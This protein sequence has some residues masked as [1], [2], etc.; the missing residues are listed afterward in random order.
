MHE[1]C[2]AQVY[3]AGHCR[4]GSG[5]HPE[6]GQQKVGSGAV[7][8]RDE[9]GHRGA[10]ED[11]EGEER[12]L[13][14]RSPRPELRCH[15]RRPRRHRCCPE[16]PQRILD[17]RLDVLAPDVATSQGIPLSAEDASS[18][19]MP[20]DLL[21]VIGER[22]A[23]RRLRLNDAAFARMSPVAVSSATLAGRRRRRQSRGPVA[24]WQSS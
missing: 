22:F 4:P 11:R 9:H 2:D 21:T 18:R 20:R 7:A 6:G 24:Q 15:A 8:H 1:T 19:R 10:D 12:E 5:H 13:R 14:E 23:A 17:E 16:S 3:R